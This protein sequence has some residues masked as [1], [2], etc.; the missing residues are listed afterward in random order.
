MYVREW[1]CVCVYV[2]G[3]VS[4]CMYVCVHVRAC[5]WVKIAKLIDNVLSLVY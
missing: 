5:V 1:V 2:S 4:V 3:Y